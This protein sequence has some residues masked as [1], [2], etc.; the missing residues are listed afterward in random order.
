MLDLAFQKLQPGGV[1]V[2]ETLN[3]A[4]WTAFFESY[5]RDITHRWPLHPETLKY[6]VTASGFT[7]ADIEFRSPVPQADRLQPIALPSSELA[8]APLAAARDAVE[9]FNSNVEKLNARL[10]TF[11]DYAVVARK[12]AADRGPATSPMDR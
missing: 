12:L 7:Q 5:I 3:P 1:L 9:A 4:C 10:F 6:L 11:M 8:G 2:L